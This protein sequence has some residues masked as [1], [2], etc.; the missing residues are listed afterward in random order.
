MSRKRD[1]WVLPAI[2]ANRV[3]SFLDTLAPYL[4]QSAALGLLLRLSPTGN[5]TAIYPL[6]QGADPKPLHGL[7]GECFEAA[8]RSAQEMHASP[9]QSTTDKNMLA[10]DAGLI[11]WVSLQ[12]IGTDIPAD[13]GPCRIFITDLP[14]AE[15]T[16]LEA[17]AMRR[18]RS[19]R[20][21]ATDARQTLIDLDAD[22]ER[23]ATIEGLRAKAGASQL[24]CLSR[25]ILGPTELW[26]DSGLQIDPDL[27]GVIAKIFNAMTQA[28]LLAPRAALHLIKDGDMIQV[29]RWQPAADAPPLEDT[30]QPVEDFA[31][32]PAS[33]ARADDLGPALRFQLLE[34]RPD[35]AAQHELNARINR[36]DFPLGYR[37][38]LADIG[39]MSRHEEDI[40][41][42]RSEI[43][44]REARIAL[45]QALGR[46]QTRLLRFYD[47]QLPAMVDG[48]R[49]MPRALRDHS[50]LQYAACHAAGRAEPHHYLIYDPEEVQLDG[51]LP[52]V[53]WRAMTE[54]SPITFWLDPHAEDARLEDPDQPRVFVPAGQRI[55]PYIDSFGASLRGT[56]KLVLGGLFADASAVLDAQDAQPAFIFAPNL[57]GPDEITVDLVD[58]QGFRPL[59]LSLRWINDHILARSPVVPDPEDRRELAE[60]LYAGQLARQLRTQS[61]QQLVAL[62]TDWAQAE[63]EIAASYAAF[64][65]AAG[66][67]AQ[68]LTDALRAA[69]SFVALS[70]RR[71]SEVAGALDGLGATLAAI[72]GDFARIGNDL[73]Q[74]PLRRIALMERF[75]DEHHAHRDFFKETDAEVERLRIRAQEL[76]QKW[77]AR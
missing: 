47:A 54:D 71:L 13:D 42:L 44:E 36:R 53:Y 28:G 22:G 69:Q 29:H 62:T 72:E 7:L 57:H 61:D 8:G 1:Y 74:A 9:P 52:E 30:M 49:R 63:I 4:A 16:Q 20:V 17:E 76:F 48:L 32:A 6:A 2:R 55:L 56:L 14:E 38:H 24:H 31:P 35:E 50:G 11:A 40:E 39:S 70:Q 43:E 5:L 41:K 58:L 25:D 73:P 34:L 77:S 3:A 33:P 65:Q 10:L 51:V 59:K 26:L 67:E 15:K 12:A 60:T 75:W 19:S 27:R 37:I 64:N 21:L 46:K 18:G 66:R 23:G 68:Q 45:I